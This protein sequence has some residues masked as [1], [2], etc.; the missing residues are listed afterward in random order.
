[1]KTKISL[2][3]GLA[4]AV[5]A[6]ALSGQTGA[7]LPALQ[8]GQGRFLT[9]EQRVLVLGVVMVAEALLLL[10]IGWSRCRLATS[11]NAR[12]TF[13]FLTL[14]YFAACSIVSARERHWFW[15]T[16]PSNDESVLFLTSNLQWV[17]PYA[18][19]HA[20]SCCWSLGSLLGSPHTLPDP[21][22]MKP[23]VSSISLTCGPSTTR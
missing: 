17:I 14:L 3:A 1:M 21:A 13:S 6:I 16:V 18:R 10:W 22:R 11:D 4:L 5:L 7:V 8:P 19:C 23:G 15:A 12:Y 2:I 20:Q 9:A